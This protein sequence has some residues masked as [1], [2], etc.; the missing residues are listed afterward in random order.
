MEHM[1]VA[2]SG[3]NKVEPFSSLPSTAMPTCFNC[4]KQIF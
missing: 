1:Y 3:I 4:I 2:M